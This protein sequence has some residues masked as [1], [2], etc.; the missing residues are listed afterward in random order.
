MGKKRGCRRQTYDVCEREEQPVRISMKGSLQLLR[1]R[2]IGQGSPVQIYIAQSAIRRMRVFTPRDT[3]IMASS[4][5]VQKGGMEIHQYTPY[6]H[7]QYVETKYRHKGI[8][9][10]HWFEAMKKNGGAAAILREAA[11]LAGA[12]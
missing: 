7:R 11:K 12:K 8:Q 9:T 1:E 2:G 3:Q 5:S 6:A 4:A 10:H